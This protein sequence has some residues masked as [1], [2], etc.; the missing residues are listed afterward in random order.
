MSRSHDQPDAPA[1]PSCDLPLARAFGVLG[2]RWNGILIASLMNGPAGFA[3][4]KRSVTGIGDSTLSDRLCELAMAGLLTRTVVDGPPVSVTYA[5][6]E[7]GAQL[8]PTLE[9]LGSWS[10]DH[11]AEE[12]C[13]EQLT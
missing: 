11:L 3:Q 1:G 13:S 6:T 5:L 4:L 2:K 7:A 12:V 8:R 9:L 10:Q